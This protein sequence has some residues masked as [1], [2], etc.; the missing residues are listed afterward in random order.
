MDDLATR[1]SALD[2]VC[3][4]SVKTLEQYELNQRAQAAELAK[5]IKS[6]V[7]LMAGALAN[8]DVAHAERVRRQARPAVDRGALS[9]ITLK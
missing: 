1:P 5:Q 7:Y 8:A 3:N 2:L 4:A 9:A 6:L